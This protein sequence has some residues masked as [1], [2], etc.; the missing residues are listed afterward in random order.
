MKRIT[1]RERLKSDTR[2]E[3]FIINEVKSATKHKFIEK[4]DDCFYLF[5]DTVL[6]GDSGIL[7]YS[8]VKV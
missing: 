7:S 5:V 3:T 1:V 2:F 8:S 4:Y 6:N